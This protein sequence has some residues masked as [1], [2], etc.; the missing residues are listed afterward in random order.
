MNFLQKTYFEQY[1]S[2]LKADLE[3]SF[4][5][6]EKIE[7]TPRNFSFYN[8]VS[9]MASAKIEGEPLEIDSFVKYKLLNVEY[10][11]ELT[12]K[13]NDLY[14]AYF[15]A[16]DNKLSFNNLMTTHSLATV[17]L[18]PEN[19]RGVIR[20]TEMLVIDNKTGNIE[21]EAATKLE[22]E[23]LFNLFFTEI[24]KILENKKL[25]IEEIFYYAAFIHLIFVK[26]HPFSDGNGRTARLLEKWFL[27]EKLDEQAWFIQSEKHYFDNHDQYYKNLARLG[28]FYDQLKYENS[29]PFV[30]MLP[31]SL[32][33]NK[34]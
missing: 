9:A 30:L 34:L 26:I 17:H 32:A 24:D 15:F 18:L 5:E 8:S 28:F 6:I 2:L 13:P 3:K 25:S 29:L 27:A 12:E 16:K 20:K 14:N 7:L 31:D 11:P 33:I 21:Y 1:K 4:A 19:Q 10:L 22:V 23:N